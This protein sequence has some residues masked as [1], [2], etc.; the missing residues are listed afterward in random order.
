MATLRAAFAPSSRAA[1]RAVASDRATARDAGS[2]SSAREGCRLAP[3]PRRLTRDA[4]ASPRV[5]VPRGALQRARGFSRATVLWTLPQE[6]KRPPPGFSVAPS[7][8][9]APPYPTPS[10]GAHFFVLA[11]ASSVWSATTSL[12]AAG[13]SASDFERDE[14]TNASRRRSEETAPGGGV[15]HPPPSRN[16]P[17]VGGGGAIIRP[18]GPPESLYGGGG[19]GSSGVSESPGSS[20]ASS[21]TSDSDSLASRSASWNAWWLDAVSCGNLEAMDML[22]KMPWASTA[23]VVSSMRVVRD[24]VVFQRV[25]DLVATHRPGELET[26]ERVGGLTAL[27]WAAKKGDSRAIATLV[28]AGADVDARDDAGVVPV[29][30]A[31]VSDSVVAAERLLLA[32]ADP[33]AK[34]KSP[35]DEGDGGW[36]A[37][38]WAAR[39]GQVHLVRTLLG[40]GADPNLP[41]GANSATPM[42]QAAMGGHA[43]CV[44]AL[45]DAG[46]DPR[47]ADAEGFTA[48]MHAGFRHPQNTKLQREIAKV[49]AEWEKKSGGGG[50]RKR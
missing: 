43:A 46:A 20:P 44:E 39:K 49:S 16:P 25:C 10:D 21:P 7:K 33:D 14:E 29:L 15:L 4:L 3:F 19:A 47:I 45:A 40:F 38:A 11:G 13:A 5:G 32:G 37:L 8:Q 22:A 2:P 17:L 12:V 36:R 42:I 18:K 50:D 34:S 1:G 31:S 48:Q 35:S 26:R 41:G 9:Y 28:A 30:H 23:I 24:P 6:T 27:A